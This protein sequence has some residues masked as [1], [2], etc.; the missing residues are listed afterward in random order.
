[1]SRRNRDKDSDA[2]EEPVP[3]EGG[4][5]SNAELAGADPAAGVTDPPRPEEADRPK[6]KPAVVHGPPHVGGREHVAGEDP[7]DPDDDRPEGEPK[8]SPVVPAD[9]VQKLYG[10]RKEGRLYRCSVVGGV[11]KLIEADSPEQAKEAYVADVRHD[12]GEA[13]EEPG[14]K[15]GKANK[16]AAPA[17][18][19]AIEVPPGYVVMGP[20][21]EPPID[22]ASVR[23]VKLAP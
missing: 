3:Y 20:A 21:P 23:A 19:P 1:M 16:A 9:N 13:P 8:P 17:K 2:P 12:R 22:V 6:E 18:A 5:P 14:T 15:K 7:V 10:L 11:T 4:G